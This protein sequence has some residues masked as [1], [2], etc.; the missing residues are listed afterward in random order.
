M[1]KTSI[2]SI[3]M[4]LLV[5]LAG[6]L[7]A[8][9]EIG[10]DVSMV[11]PLGPG[12]ADF[13][14][15]VQ[16]DAYLTASPEP[17][18]GVSVGGALGYQYSQTTGGLPLNTVMLRALGG[19]PLLTLPFMTLSAEIGAGGYF[20][21]YRPVED[22]SDESIVYGG[23]AQAQLG[24]MSRFTLPAGLRI[25]AGVEYSY[26]IG[27]KADLLA[28]LTVSLDPQQFAARPRIDLEEIYIDPV[29]P[30]LVH[31]YRDNPIGTLAFVNRERGPIQDV[32]LTVSMPG[33]ADSDTLAFAQPEMENDVVQSIPVRILLP[34]DTVQSAVAETT[35]AVLSIDYVYEDREKHWET[36][37][38][39]TVYN[40]NAIV[41]DDDG[42]A[43]AFVTALD[44]GILEL[45][46]NAVSASSSWMLTEYPRGIAVGSVMLSLLESQQL[47]YNPDPASPFSLADTEGHVDFVQFP[48]E[49]LQYKAGDCDDLTVLY[50]AL[51]EAAGVP[52]AFI[53]VP[54][55]IFAAIGLDISAREAREWVGDSSMIAEHN[56]RAWVPV[57]V[58]ELRGGFARAWEIGSRQWVSNVAE[59]EAAL[60][61]LADA[62][63]AYPAV[64][65]S[66]ERAGVSDDVLTGCTR[67]AQT[68]YEGIVEAELYERETELLAAID[69]RSSP[70]LRNRL[71]VLYARFGRY[72]EARSTLS[73]LVSD[74]PSF[75]P[76]HVNLGYVYFVE[77]QFRDAERAFSRAARL[78]P[79]SAE[80]QLALARCEYEQGMTAAASDRYDR[81][82]EMSAELATDF[83]YLGAAQEGGTRASQTVLSPLWMEEP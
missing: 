18:G 63:D 17:L 36:A 79:A 66:E 38:E 15:G 28:R 1:A 43:A 8:Q 35:T 13:G 47:S 74:S 29:F 58:T 3:G 9:T 46:R 82:A 45:S 26:L 7:A 12:A 10:A 80:I 11:L 64:S 55:H 60:I 71:G 83:A 76:A 67:E 57:E 22:L 16:T 52:A 31:Y 65:Y 34:S 44:P 70:R 25:S 27:L 62:W 72:R 77:D 37:T 41:W 75:A 54:G 69:R 73:S 24:V 78:D 59:G 53:T 51:L 23:G 61:P 68:Q 42:K 14:L 19:L 32:R 21:M 2:Q 20:G 30:S 5:L 48:I 56:G 40:R 81:V 39:I 6:E 50:C 4:A 33:L 49:T